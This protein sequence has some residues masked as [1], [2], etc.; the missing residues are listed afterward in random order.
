MPVTR[1]CVVV[2]VPAERLWAKLSAYGTWHTWLKEVSESH[3]EGHDTAHVPIGA[4]RAVHTNGVLT[5]R[6]RLVSCDDARRVISY[7][8]A[9][10]P[11]WRA[12][13]R[14]YRGSAAVIALTDGARSAV[15]WSGTYD[16]DAKDEDYMAELL[17]GL[18]QSFINGLAGAA[19]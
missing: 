11:Q 1:V 13:A 19:G 4:V 9:R 16:C 7:E 8:V 5:V 10:E 15:E 12:P 17:T 18:Y 3:I 6:E 2:D 14:R